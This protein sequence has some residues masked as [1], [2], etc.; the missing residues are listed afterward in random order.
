MARPQFSE[1]P[2]GFDVRSNSPI[3]RRLVLTKEEME[4]MVLHS[5]CGKDINL[6]SV[7]PDSYFVLCED[8]GR[9]YKNSR[10]TRDDC[11]GCKIPDKDEWPFVTSNGHFRLFNDVKDL[12]SLGYHVDKDGK[13]VPGESW[14]SIVD[15]CGIARVCSQEDIQII[16]NELNT[17]F[18]NRDNA[19]AEKASVEDLCRVENRVTDLEE[20]SLRLDTYK[21]DKFIVVGSGDKLVDGRPV[22]KDEGEHEAFGVHVTYDPKDEDGNPLFDGPPLDSEGEKRG[23]VIYIDHDYR[24]AQTITSKYDIGGIGKGQT[25]LKGTPLETFLWQLLRGDP[26]IENIIYWKASDILPNV[27][28]AEG[29]ST[30]TW[31]GLGPW[32]GQ[33]ATT[34]DDLLN[35]PDTKYGWRG[36]LYID[37]FITNDQYLMFAVPRSNSTALKPDDTGAWVVPLMNSEKAPKGIRLNEIYLKDAPEYKVNFKTARIRNEDASTEWGYVIYYIDLKTYYPQGIDWVAEFVPVE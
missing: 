27:P 16:I 34:N 8:N 4:N 20:E 32:G 13:L 19:L 35:I 15:K 10:L 2:F 37:G 30:S 36:D 33:K 1:V 28:D 3:D 6:S 31:T 18:V 23:P 22:P 21:A 11:D 5:N 17:R 12:V 7:F 9:L 29:Y 14:E 24:F 25:I 26:V